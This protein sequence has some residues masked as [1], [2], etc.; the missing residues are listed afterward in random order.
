MLRVPPVY[1]N[2]I[3]ARNGNPLRYIEEHELYT[4]AHITGE[5][6]D[7]FG[8]YKFL[9]LGS[10]PLA[11][12]R[13]HARAAIVLRL[14][15]HT[16]EDRELNAIDMSQTDAGYYHGGTLVDEI[17]ALASLAM[18]IRL[19]AGEHTRR[20]DLDGDPLGEPRKFGMSSNPVV[21]FG[22]YGRILP[23]VIGEHP[24]ADLEPLTL[25][26][27]LSPSDAIVL[28]CTARLYQDALWI[29]ESEPSLAWVMLVSAIETAANHWRSDS[30]TPLERFKA[31]KPDLVE[32]LE[33]TGDEGL[34]EYVAD[35]IEG[36]LGSTKKFRDFIKAFKPDPP[37]KRPEEWAQYSWSGKNFTRTMNKIYNYR[38]KALHD[39][40][41]FPAPMC[42][43]PDRLQQW[44]VPAEK[45]WGFAAHTKGGTWVA[46]DTPMH[47]HIFEYIV[48]NVL[49][50]WW[51][52]MEA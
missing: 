50:A 3:A 11:F 2:W 4:D 28:I 26:P 1:E 51:T 10:M 38:S 14:G 46:S 13:G 19:K 25:L 39:G 18:G 17:A 16:E 48:R 33:A 21:L 42:E 22:S 8:P 5:I 41:P 32:R 45:P 12:Q 15:I 6:T 20:F 40:R 36:S 49:I 24:L 43:P 35:E 23:F 9:N 27:N 44:E 29:A 34:A 47:L 30:G 31:S 37:Q 52:S 7:G